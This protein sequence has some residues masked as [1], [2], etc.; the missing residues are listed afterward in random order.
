MNTAKQLSARERINA[1]L[2]DNSFVEIGA[3]VTKRSTDFNLSQKEISSDGVITGYGIIDGNPVYVYS[4]DSTAAGG[5]IG[6]MHAKKIIAVYDLALKVGAPVIGLIDSA[7][8][9]LQEATDALN[10]L[11]EIYR[12]Q[13]MASGVIPQITAILGPCGGGL[14]VLGALSDFSF[15]TE[16]GSKLFVNSPNA[17]KKN[18]T[19]KCDTASAKY[20]AQA[21]NIDFMAES[22]E[23]VFER[24]RKL[25]S[26]LPA[27]FEDDASFDECYDDLNRLIPEAVLKQKDTSLLL[28]EISDDRSFLETKPEYAREMVTGFLRLNGMTVGAVANR[29]GVLDEEGQSLFEHDGTLTAKGCKK[30]SRFIRFCDAFHI[31]VLSVTDAEGFKAEVSEEALLAGE[32]AALTYA[33]ASATVPKVNLIVGKAFGSAY[34]T[35]NS[36]HIGADMVFALEKASIGMMDENEAVNIIYDGEE[37]DLK[38]KAKEYREL[39]S[40]AMSA[41]K[42]GY[43]DAIIEDTSVRKHLIYAFE[44]LF[45]K[46]VHAPGGKHG[47][48][49]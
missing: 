40:S 47:T 33:F 38:D 48:V 36:K 4:Q 18:F 15:M 41:A 2:D 23:E 49:L 22:E 37:T 3:L 6:E 45:T 14:A 24:I 21:G 8:L 7:G 28:R 34:L 39:Q 10:G 35:M 43:V 44:M 9:R 11:G 46:S 16:S 30:A 12:K 27:S 26:L 25:I 1:L 42:R 13:T 19:A 5:T 20:Q 31:P 17:L 29:R 32:A